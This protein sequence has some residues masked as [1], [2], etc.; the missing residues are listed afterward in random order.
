MW[1][2]ASPWALLALAAV[3]IVLGIYLFRT[4]SRRREVSS[5]FLWVDHHRAQQGGRRIEHLQLPLLILLELLVFALL[6]LAAAGPSIRGTQLGR[7]LVLV[8]DA[9]YSMT[10]ALPG[11]KSP[12]EQ[13]ETAMNEFFDSRAT[14]PIQFVTAGA[15]PEVFGRRVR[16]PAEAKDVLRQWRCDAPN[17]SVMQAIT[18]AATVAPADARIL[19]L[20]DKAPPEPI[21]QG[22]VEW[23]AF[24]K[25]QDNLAIV[26]ANRTRQ[27]ERDRLLLEIANRSHSARTM[28]LVLL[29][30]ARGTIVHET[31]QPL[32]AG[33]LF[34]LRST[35]PAGV[36]MLDVRLADDALLLDNRMPLLP[37]TA[38]QVRVRIDE[39]PAD[40]RDRLRRAVETSGI[41]RIV[42]ELPDLV[43]IDAA[44]PSTEHENPAETGAAVPWTV[45]V[46][47]G[48]EDGDPLIGPFIL[49]R[50]SPLT[51][52]VSLEGIVWS[53]PPETMESPLPGLPV[54]A[55]ADVP[56]L[57]EQTL[58]HG[59]K[60]FHLALQNRLSTITSQPP[61]PALIWNLLQYRNRHAPGVASP[62][63]K[64]GTNVLFTA[65]VGERSATLTEPDGKSRVIPIRS[66]TAQ[67]MTT[68][69]GLYAIRC[70]SETY[71]FAVGT[72]SVEE[73]DLSEATSGTFGGWLDEET[74]RTDYYS[75]VWMLL[76]ASL[77]VLAVHL[78]FLRR[79]D[80]V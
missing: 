23:R 72:L 18:F 57:T 69:C 30:V 80:G 25:P 31:S 54:I 32:A 59:V 65:P 35:V 71:S 15:Q 14:W 28:N 2:L 51:T 42:T 39:A 64:L 45:R 13:A 6:A 8:L 61:W 63:V 49:D 74:I 26:H 44:A 66:G 68:Q 55:A 33:E 19:V 48:G 76:L 16:T 37:P 46:H 34:R 12:R 17:D 75:I 24:G 77:V 58:R 70:A 20:T 47:S 38:H 79:R 27:G 3:P 40:L 36:E 43:F 60:V 9:S 53:I 22:R 7:P 67:I 56:L 50:T 29:D 52:G 4:R 11:E 62:N 78:A 5:L 21:T 41:G 73:S 10:A 1:L